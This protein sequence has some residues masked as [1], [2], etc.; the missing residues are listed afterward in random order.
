MKEHVDD[1]GCPLIRSEGDRKGIYCRHYTLNIQ[2]HIPSFRRLSPG[3]YVDKL[4]VSPLAEGHDQHIV[5]V[6]KVITSTL[7]RART[8]NHI[9]SN[10]HTD[11]GW[12]AASQS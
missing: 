9:S 3:F 8:R 5:F 6:S 7:H 12:V 1:Q 10:T 4:P 11:L 2:T